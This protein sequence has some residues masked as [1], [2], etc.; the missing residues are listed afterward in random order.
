MHNVFQKIIGDPSKYDATDYDEFRRKSAIV[1]TVTLARQENCF[2]VS[3][4]FT[5]RGN[6]VLK[7]RL[8]ILSNFPE[9]LN[10]KHYRSLLPEIID[11]EVVDWE[12]HRLRFSDWS[13]EINLR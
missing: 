6:D 12:V 5:F 10:P 3:I 7:Y 2:A 4:M 11:N 1:N 9:T 13:E 8:P